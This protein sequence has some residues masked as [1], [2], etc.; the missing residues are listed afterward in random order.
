ME[1]KCATL[2]S[3]IA[4]WVLS[5]V[6]TALAACSDHGSSAHPADSSNSTEIGSASGAGAAGGSG[7]TDPGAGGAG[8]CGGAGG[9]VPGAGG[10]IQPDDPCASLTAPGAR[11]ARVVWVTGRD[12]SLNVSTEIS[13]LWSFQYAVRVPQGH[14]HDYTLVH[15]RCETPAGGSISCSS[16]ELALSSAEC[17]V[18]YAPKFGVDPGQYEEGKNIYEF[19]LRLM[20]GCRVAS[21]DAFTI[22]LTYT[23]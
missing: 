15:E 20:Q 5:A 6:G 9:E 13:L 18:S 11:D 3:R 4:P 23:P 12:Q 16:G 10:S 19:K 21:A 22:D 17:K 2:L 1:Q 7:T 14:R 8:G